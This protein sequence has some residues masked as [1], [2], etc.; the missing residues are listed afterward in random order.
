MR[1]RSI[2][3]NGWETKTGVELRLQEFRVT[4]EASRVAVGLTM[5]Y[6]AR[7]PLS[8]SNLFKEA[9]RT[10]NETREASNISAE[11]SEVMHSGVER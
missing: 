4:R 8:R 6:Q 1:A 2:S 10:R 11:T 3:S 9:K 5:Y 7:S